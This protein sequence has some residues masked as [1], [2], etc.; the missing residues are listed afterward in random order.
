[1]RLSS[2][3][4]G[5]ETGLYRTDSRHCSKINCPP[6]R[7]PCQLSKKPGSVEFSP[8]RVQKGREDF[9]GQKADFAGFGSL[10]AIP[11]SALR[12]IK[13]A[14][15]IWIPDVQAGLPRRRG[16]PSLPWSSQQVTREGTQAPSQ[17]GGRAGCWAQLE[18]MFLYLGGS[19]EFKVSFFPFS[20]IKR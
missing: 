2:C 1:M 15:S 6:L 14:S 3:P 8:E 13:E 20:P 4:K 17:E 5:Q 12:A 9:S 18:A 19:H 11:F 7:I 16:C 10:S